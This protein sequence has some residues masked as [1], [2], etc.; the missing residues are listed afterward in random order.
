MPRRLARFHRACNVNRAREQQKLFSQSGLAR[1][2]VR[3]D[4]K[5]AAAAGF[6]GESH[7]GG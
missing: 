3:D 2:G 4:G 1:I 6:C 5:G 7:D